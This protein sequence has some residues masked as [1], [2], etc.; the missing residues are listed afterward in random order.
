[1]HQRRLRHD[2]A[3]LH[4]QRA[5]LPE[6]VHRRHGLPGRH[7]VPRGGVFVGGAIAAALAA[8]FYPVRISR[9]S[10]DKVVR[11]S[12]RMF[13]EMPRQLKGKKVLIV[14]DVAA[15]G[16]TL[17]LAKALAAKVGAKSVET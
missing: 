10:R 17:E 7:G 14:D 1:M 4:R 16:D 9:R 2:A 6:A 5:H 8:D 13:G 11:R 12:P 3:A 15:S